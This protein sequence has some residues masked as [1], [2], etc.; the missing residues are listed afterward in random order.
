MYWKRILIL[1]LS[2]SLLL[3]PTAAFAHDGKN[4]GNGEATVSNPAADLRATLDHLLSEHAY[5]AVVA[6]QKGIDGAEDFEATANALGE[7][8]NDLTAA[9][10]S[11]YGK[12]G[13]DAF[14]KMWSDHIG[15]FVD[16]VKATANN[17]EEGRTAALSAL[18]EYRADFSQFL[19][20]ATEG[21]LEVNALAEGLQMHV[22]QLVA[23]FDSYVAGDYEKA[24]DSLGKAHEHM[25]AIGKGLS[26][27]ISTQFPDTFK[28]SDNSTP[29][30]ELRAT[31]NRLLSQHA[32]IAIL[33][34]QKGIDGKPDFEAVA[35]ALN[36]NT[37]GLK[38]AI[39]S[40]YGSEA[41]VAF[42]EMWSA[43]IGF[44]VDYVVATSKDDN[45]GRTAALSSLSQY[46]A[47]FS[48]FLSTATD[49]KLDAT[50]L[51]GGLQMHVDQLVTAFDSYVEG[52][53][54]TTYTNVR[55]AFHHMFGVGEALSG[56]IVQQF[57]EKFEHT[58]PSEMPKTGMGGVSDSYSS[59][60]YS[61]MDMIMILVGIAFATVLG[62][63]LRKQVKILS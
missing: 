15:F 48:Q 19:S 55:E 28:H 62:I 7:N 37:A 38:A 40:V 11:V 4:H 47:D 2:L 6:M 8:T 36:E 42:E 21:K 5:L 32:S 1:V 10:E 51:A 12:E 33:A 41:G 44:F 14:N 46:R 29:A 13:A 49:G 52:D 53:F 31:L 54:T 57:P 61:M 26:G 20:T 24:Y 43:H 45:A 9:I 39:S 23:A 27:A 3:L 56:A 25:F 34:M 18:S 58:M 16:Y 30:A 22:G 50:A 59:N 17:D 35:G 60:S 63:F